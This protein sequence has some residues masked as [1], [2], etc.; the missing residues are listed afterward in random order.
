MTDSRAVDEA[1]IEEYWDWIA[2]ALFLL[3]VVDLLTT[4]AAVRVVGLGSEGNPLMRW[5]LGRD[6]NVVVV[7]HLAAA[8]LVTGCF[9][10]LTGRLRHTSPPAD[11]YFALLIEA[12]LGVLVAVGLAVFANN[13]AVIV[14]GRS[15]L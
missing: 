4:L 3:L 13:L 5:L 9:R 8:V 1:R 7:V 15:L 6:V 2:V 14:L 12:W 10:L 11:R